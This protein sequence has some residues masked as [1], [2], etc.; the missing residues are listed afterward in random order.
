PIDGTV[1]PEATPTISGIAESD[2]T[3]EVF[4]EGVSQGRTTADGSGDWTFTPTSAW[5][6][7]TYSI[8][9]KA[10]DTG[11][12]T[13]VGSEAV[14]LTIDTTA[15]SAPSI[16]PSTALIRSPEATPTIS[17]IAEADSTIEVFSDGI[18]QGTT[19]ADGSGD[20]TFTPTSA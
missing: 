9:V 2:S 18:S 4:R 17:G 1:S 13:S 8:T 6:D 3:V 15:P 14:V 7:G 16:T 10:T 12:N 5:P 20:W 11:G 19:T